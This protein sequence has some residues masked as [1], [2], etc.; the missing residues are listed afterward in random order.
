VG[1]LRIAIRFAFFDLVDRGGPGPVPDDT[2][3]AIAVLKNRIGGKHVS[4][5]QEFRAEW[6]DNSYFSIDR[7]SSMGSI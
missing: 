5:S 2:H 3:H 4:A 6:I 1:V 7:D